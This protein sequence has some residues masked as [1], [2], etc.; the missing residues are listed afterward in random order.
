MK[1]T[2][3]D[4][5]PIVR[6]LHLEYALVPPKATPAPDRTLQESLEASHCPQVQ[7]PGEGIAVLCCVQLLG[8]PIHIFLNPAR[9]VVEQDA[10]EP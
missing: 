3:S 2:F 8:F 5:L 6:S 10:P 9:F 1:K 7:V 4:N